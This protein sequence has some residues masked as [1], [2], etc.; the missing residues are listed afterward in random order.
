MKFIDITARDMSGAAKQRADYVTGTLGFDYS[1]LVEVAV[2]QK[3]G[4]LWIRGSD[5]F[6]ENTEHRYITGRL[7]YL[8]AFDADAE[9]EAICD[10]AWE[11]LKRAMKRDE[12]ELRHGLG[13]MG[14]VI[15]HTPSYTS[16]VG[17]MLAERILA[18]RDEASAH[19]IEFRR[20]Q[21]GE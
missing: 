17:K 14:G 21:P 8:D 3:G 1:V 6:Q 5:K 18:A 20:S 13:V 15:E 12:R 11:K 19:L 10:R 16:A 4:N 7:A 9:W 2:T